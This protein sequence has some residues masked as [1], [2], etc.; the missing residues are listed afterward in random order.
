M[1]VQKQ[2]PKR[3]AN[4]KKRRSG[5]IGAIARKRSQ[6]VRDLLRRWPVDAASEAALKATLKPRQRDALDALNEAIEQADHSNRASA[7]E[8]EEYPEAVEHDHRLLEEAL[9]RAIRARLQHPLVRELLTNMRLFGERDELGRLGRGY[10]RGVKPQ[11]SSADAFLTFVLADI[12]EKKVQDPGGFGPEAL[13][14]DLLREL[15]LVITTGLDDDPIATRGA[16][17]FGLTRGNIVALHQRIKTMS[18]QGF[19]KLFNRLNLPDRGEQ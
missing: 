6:Y 16:K 7:Q 8:R 5:V 15:H 14:R 3:W 17:L 2:P 10:E 9:G 19:H 1:A 11:M 4:P 12:I 18:R 13:R